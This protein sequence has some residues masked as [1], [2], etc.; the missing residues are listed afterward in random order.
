MLPVSANSLTP[1]PSSLSLSPPSLSLSASVR[2]GFLHTHHQAREGDEVLTVCVGAFEPEKFG[3][4]FNLIANTRDKTASKGEIEWNLSNQ[5]T[6]GAE[7]VPLSVRCPHSEV[8][9]HARVVLGVGKGVLFR[10]V[11]STQECP[12][13]PVFHTAGFPISILSRF[14]SVV[15]GSDFVVL[16]NEQVGP[17]DRANRIRCM[18]VR[19]IDDNVCGDDP[20]RY[21][22]IVLSTHDNHVIPDPDIT[23]VYIYDAV[24]CS[25]FIH[26]VRIIFMLFIALYLSL[27]VCVSMSV[28]VRVG[29]VV[30]TTTVVEDEREATVCANVFSPPVLERDVTVSLNTLPVS[31]GLTLSLVTYSYSRREK[32]FPKSFA[33]LPFNGVGTMKRQNGNGYAC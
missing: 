23:R 27:F 8:E 7:E 20:G 33:V 15:G 32:M 21:F 13:V 30:T 17:L 9:M 14:H 6:N 28:L 31:A 12:E 1:A 24:D 29:L 18:R 22:D 5:G 25:E 19:L 4:R 26:A 11:S 3:A 2:A 10:E 16:D